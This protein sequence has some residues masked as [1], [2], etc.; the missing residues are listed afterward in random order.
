MHLSTSTF[1]M[2][3]LFKHLFKHL[4]KLSRVLKAV[5]LHA[6]C[7]NANDV[8]L[9][10]WS[11]LAERNFVCMA[12]VKV[13]QTIHTKDCACAVDVTSGGDDV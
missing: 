11:S 9:T 6:S 12:L 7:A 13:T 3:Y 8:L 5:S 10:G 2:K 1:F 4:L